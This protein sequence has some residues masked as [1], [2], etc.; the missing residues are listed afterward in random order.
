MIDDGLNI[1]GRAAH[2]QGLAPSR[3]N[4][5]NGRERL[6]LKTRDGINLSRLDHVQQ[7]V[8]D[9]SLLL[10]RDLGRANIQPTIDL[11]RISRNNLPPKFP[12]QRNPQR[13]FA[14][15]GRPFYNHQF[16]HVVFISILFQS[17]RTQRIR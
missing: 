1:M 17:Q 6:L 14:G 11:A 16:L 13:A 10:R 7:M 4:I 5:L 15:S 3:A 12:R 8:W 9:Q 2:E